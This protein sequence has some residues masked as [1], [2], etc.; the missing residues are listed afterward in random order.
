MRESQSNP[1]LSAPSKCV[2][3]ITIDRDQ[4]YFASYAEEGIVSVWDRR[5]MGRTPGVT[6]PVLLFNRATQDD[7]GE[8][9]RITRLEYS[10][11][12]AGVLAVLN[13]SGQLRV[14]ETA[15]LT[16]LADVARGSNSYGVV[17]EKVSGVRRWMSRDS[18]SLDGSSRASRSSETIFVTKIND[19]AHPSRSGG[20]P[21]KRICSFDWMNMGGGTHTGEGYVGDLKTVCIKN[22]GEVEVLSLTGSVLAI[23]I[24]SKN[25]FAVTRGTGLI[26]L[27]DP[28]LAKKIVPRTQ[29]DRMS[30]DETRHRRRASESMDDQMQIHSSH[31]TD[32]G[33][34]RRA[35]P[36][37]KDS[38]ID[39]VFLLTPEEV[40]GNDIC[41][42]MKARVEK[43]YGMN[44][45]IPSMEK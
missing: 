35:V 27:P 20:K 45:S 1:A 34:S 44:V 23:A 7:R 6:E 13:K 2:F 14:Y 5:A 8:P 3:G 36:E 16:D 10:P 12:K 17:D 42:V 19:L 40:L 41:V 32:G 24:S 11:Q 28:T 9:G 18:G 37:R 30:P 26:V 25:R 15:K 38:L 22:N 33:D 21:D 39:G 43:G 4:N 31:G 29:Q